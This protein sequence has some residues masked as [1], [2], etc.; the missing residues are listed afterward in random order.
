MFSQEK[1]RN[2]AIIAHVDHGKTTLVDCLLKQSGTL[3]TIQS[4]GTRVMDNNELE[5]ERGIT[6]LSKCTSL[7]Y[8]GNRINIVDTPGHADFGGEVERILTMVDGVVLIVDAT[9]GP[10]AQTKFVL[11]KA[12]KRGLKPLVVF[13][14]VDR[15]TSRPEEVDSEL[16]DLFSLLGA[17]DD[18]LD[19]PILYASAKEG[20]ATKDIGGDKSDGMKPLLDTFLEFI[21]KPEGD[22]SAPFKMLVTQLESNTFLGKCYLGRINSG[23]IKVGDPIRSLNE[24]G[25][26]VEENRITKI[27]LQV[28]LEKIVVEEA[29]AG[30]IVSI[31][32]ITNAGVNTT[33]CDPNID[34]PLPSH[35]VDPPTVSMV[36]SVNNSPLAGTEGKLLT[37][38]VIG[39]RLLKEAE[40][41]VALQIVSQ[42]SS[43]F[44]VRG[45][46]E[47]QLG[48]LIETMRR[49]GFE[50]GISPPRVVFQRGEKKDDILEPIEEV[51]IDVEHEFT[52][53]V[54]EKL[55]KRKGELKSFIEFGDKARLILHVPTRGLLGYS[56]EFKND[57]HGQGTLNHIFYEYQSY[58]GPL[59]KIRKGSLLS[60]AKGEV[61]SYAANLMEPRGKL[62]VTPGMQVYPGMVVGE[63]NKDD[64]DLEVN[65][66]RTK[67]VN[68]MRTVMKDE[69][70]K[71]TAVKPMSLE[72]VIAYVAPDEIIEVTPKSIRLRKKELDP[73]KRKQAAKQLLSQFM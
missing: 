25:K 33:L 48:V 27:F 59:D 54:I 55:S 7:V 17:N 13:N 53:I 50:L 1:I 12:L 68:N 73:S 71:L 35:K 20:W 26:V 14:K 29:G 63:Y 51:T 31:A 40:T 2:L 43:S 72:E 41:N 3:S 70:I 6:I 38:T 44:E 61:T 39:N 62:F 69:N 30:D 11:Q 21:P 67:A 32:G 5:R 65:P 34:T 46:G 45:R 9:E 8:K 47:L 37:S 28:G 56:A 4:G 52:G 19:Y 57:T 36:F 15:P 66:A 23:K 58:K 18:Q 22:R 60:T 10:M 24:E 42:G 16:L 64:G 49:E